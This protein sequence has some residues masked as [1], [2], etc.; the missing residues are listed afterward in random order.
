MAY[1]IVQSV[2][3]ASFSGTGGTTNAFGSNTTIDNAMICLIR[4]DRYDA[5]PTA[6]A[7]PTAVR[8]GGE[9]FTRIGWISSTG[10]LQEHV[11][12]AAVTQ[13]ASTAITVTETVGANC[14]VVDVVAFEASGMA[15][16]GSMYLA[17]SVT[18]HNFTGTGSRSSGNFGTLSGSPALILALAAGFSGAAFTTDTG[19][20]AIGSTLLSHR[21]VTSTTNT[22]ASVNA[23]ADGNLYVY[24]FALLEAAGGGGSAA[25]I[26]AYYNM[27]RRH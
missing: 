13:A 14:D 9:T 7:A 12:A 8:S 22:D 25:A 1:A 2:T 10:G 18:Q 4:I 21:R 6:D 23:T 20:T 5:S 26:V 27:L 15:A 17:G 16:V 24:G 19:Y 3:A 11:F